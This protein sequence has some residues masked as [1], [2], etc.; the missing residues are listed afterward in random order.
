MSLRSGSV[1]SSSVV[2]S[3]GRGSG[4]VSIGVDSGRL[5]EATRKY[6]H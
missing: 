1:S 5:V 2:S 3:V 4:V 6:L